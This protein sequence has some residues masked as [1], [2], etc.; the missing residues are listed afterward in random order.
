MTT[1]G[2]F[3]MNDVTGFLAQ[4]GDVPSVRDPDIVRR[5]SRD[6]SM[7]FSPIIRRD[8]A[9]K[10]CDVI[11]QPRNL[12]DVITVA[13]AAALTGMP[14][15]MRG[16]GTCNLGQGVPLHGGAL[17]DM[18][19]MNQVLWVR[20]PVARM[21]A[22]ARLLNIDEATRPHGWE[23]RMHSSTKRAATIGGY[24]AGGHA[25]IGSCNHGILRD[26]GNI[27]GLQ[28]VSVEAEPK[29]HEVRGDEVNL[30]HHAYGTNGIITEV[31]MPLAPAW[32]WIESVVNFPTF[33]DAARCAYALAASDG[34]I[35]K[36]ISIDEWPNWDYM[37]AMRPFGQ[38]G[39]SMVRAMVA[40]H[41]MEAWR[42]LVA[43]HGGS[44]SVEAPEGQ[45]PY[46]APLWEFGWGH[47][48]LHV[49]KTHPEIVNNIGL[50]LDPDLLACVERSH[51][52]FQGLGGMH[53]EAKRY[54]GRIA[55]QGSP[56]YAYADE[57]QVAA[58]M[59]GMSEDGAMVA[60]N[61]TFFVK[62]NGMKTVDERVLAFKRRMDPHG[63]MNPGKMDVDGATEKQGSGV[64]LPTTGWQYGQADEASI[65]VAA[66]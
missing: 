11:V 28:M 2:V 10:F 63:L 50:Y 62:E 29:V 37:E 52:R 51:R 34:I 14:L 23:L 8:A 15:M 27:L 9:G 21:Q 57:A 66:A 18:S 30:A 25:G 54:D 46:H 31:E 59:K 20:G 24:I 48:R 65:A 41:G 44:I 16:A 4:L 64:G 19:G 58:V 40:E 45:G 55:F 17:V 56:Y 22:G 13:R 12:D 3:H 38:S 7:T 32:P 33:M 5:R 47:A 49:N 42:A 61:H 53:L 6:M 36:L 60:N 35:K 1:I 39:H 26:R 43:E